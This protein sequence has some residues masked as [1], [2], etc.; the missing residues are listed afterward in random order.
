MYKSLRN[1]LVLLYTVSTGFILIVVMIILLVVM[2]MKLEEKRIETFKEHGDTIINKLQLENLITHSWLSQME[3]KNNLIIHIEDNGIPLN[4]RGVLPIPSNRNQLI[5]QLK[6]LA[7]NEGIVTDKNPIFNKIVKSKV[8]KINGLYKDL[9]YGLV[10]ILP[11]DSGWRNLIL[12]QYLPNYYSSIISQR[13]LFSLLALGGIICL[14]LI[15]FL[16]VSKMLK[17]VEESKNKQTAF[18]AA[19][20]H[21]LRSPLSV[22]MGNCAAISEPSEETKKFLTGI[23]KECKRM[24]RLINDMLQLACMDA[25]SWQ[26]KKEDIETDTLLI[27][28]YEVF[29]PL[30]N[31]KDI[32]LELEL[33]EEELPII[34]GDKDRLKQVLAILLDNA[35]SY[36]PSGKKVILRGY[37]SNR[38]FNMEV[39]DH[40]VG[41]SDVEKKFIFDRFYRADKSRNNK[42]HFG[43]GLCIAHEIIQLL[44]GKIL[45][46]DTIGGGATFVVKMR[47]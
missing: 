4:F 14:F 16:F 45:V 18:I 41:I 47:L 35:L 1:K 8:F 17:P 40:G 5:N 44:G 36:T 24:A 32:C 19:A 9:Y 25:K 10:V 27:E 42:E 46:K 43:L 38:H 7:L 20:S 30:F 15:S 2:E 21:E 11:T 3:A 37:I 26:I 34:N 31:Q 28:T 29:L 6:S 23:D 39:E 12:L 22:I 13:I 33:Q